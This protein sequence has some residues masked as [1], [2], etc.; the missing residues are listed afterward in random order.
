MKIPGTGQR[1]YF[2][3]LL[4]AL[5]VSLLLVSGCALGTGKEKTGSFSFWKKEKTEKPIRPSK[6][7]GTPVMVGDIFDLER[8]GIH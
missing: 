5:C 4:L 6:E 7:P 3:P 2:I 8:P 1:R